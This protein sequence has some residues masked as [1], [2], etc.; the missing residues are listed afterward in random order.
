MQLGLPD[1]FLFDDEDETCIDEELGL[2]IFLDSGNSIGIAD[3]D[4]IL[5]IPR[6]RPT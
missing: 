5:S 4:I 6:R 1:F 2:G 3:Q